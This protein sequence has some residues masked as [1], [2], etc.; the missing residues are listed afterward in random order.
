MGLLFVALALVVFVAGAI[1]FVTL[2]RFAL[3]GITLSGTTTEPRALIVSRVDAYLQAPIMGVV[4]RRTIFTLGARELEEAVLTTFPRLLSA[5]VQWSGHNTV[6]LSLA[7]RKPAFLWGQATSTP[8][9]LVDSVGYIFARARE[10]EIATSTPAFVFR[11]G[12]LGDGAI[13]RYVLPRDSFTWV[14]LVRDE[15]SHDGTTLISVSPSEQGDFIFNTNEGWLLKAN[16][17]DDNRTIVSALQSVLAV[18]DDKSDSTIDRRKSLEYVDI[19]FPNKA[20]FRMRDG[21]VNQQKNAT[22]TQPL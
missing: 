22:T 13:G 12:L 20:Y 18:V 11:G 10:S 21:V 17:R 5:S 15:L 14:G 7:D 16:M 3:E 1:W 19:R 2:P 8:Q 6:S 4:P 9:Y